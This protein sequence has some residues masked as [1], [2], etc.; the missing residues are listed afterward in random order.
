M[1]TDLWLWALIAA[2]LA[3]TLVHGGGEYMWATVQGSTNIWE[4]NPTTLSAQ[5]TCISV[6]TTNLPYGGD[7]NGAAYDPVRFDFLWAYP[8]TSTGDPSRGLYYWRQGMNQFG[9][10]AG[11]AQ[12][13]IMPTNA[14]YYQDYYYVLESSSA[15]TAVLQRVK[16]NYSSITGLPNGI[17]ARESYTIAV[18]GSVQD[19]LFVDV[20][21][22]PDDMVVYGTMDYSTSSTKVL[23]K[24]NITSLANLPLQLQIVGSAQTTN[25]QMAFDR[26]YTTLYGGRGEGVNFITFNLQTGVATPVVG[27][28]TYNDFITDLGGS[29]FRS[30]VDLVG[31][32][33]FGVNEF[34]DIV[35]YDLYAKTAKVALVTSIKDGNQFSN[36]VAYDRTRNHVFFAYTNRASPSKNGLYVWE[37]DNPAGTEQRIATLAELGVDPPQNYPFANAVFYEDAYWFILNEELI[38]RKVPITYSGG[39][40]TASGVG[41]YTNYTLSGLDFT[42]ADVQ[43]GDIVI[44]PVTNTLYGALNSD[45]GGYFFYIDLSSPSQPYELVKTGQNLPTLQLAY[46]YNYETLYA[47]D[48]LSGRWYT[49]DGVNTDVRLTQVPD[50]GT[51]GAVLS[52]RDLGGGAFF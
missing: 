37:R 4:C 47:H 35:Q 49:V 51:S 41:A 23:Y 12:L 27:S 20:A 50:F 45:T 42:D 25:Y 43:M 19:M 22:K 13:G 10:F 33:L 34:N 31:Y 5:G 36:G 24:V 15:T 28:D 21:L 3:P 40:Q 14:F 46:T 11:L 17:G 38:L 7:M 29:S 48:R 8:G 44:N 18:P 52:A 26:T 39:N 2:F 16:I 6:L 32:V 9:Q 30:A 1:A